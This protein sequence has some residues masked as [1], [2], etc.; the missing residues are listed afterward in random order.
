MQASNL[1]S[2]LR[3]EFQNRYFSFCSREPNAI[4]KKASNFKQAISSRAK[5]EHFCPSLTISFSLIV[6]FLLQ[7][8]MREP[9]LASLP[10]SL[11][12]LPVR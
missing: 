12:F 7:L 9:A 5:Y 8:I 3:A 1:R 6:A 11:H 4:C 10:A 2:G